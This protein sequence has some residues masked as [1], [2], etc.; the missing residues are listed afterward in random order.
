MDLSNEFI[1]KQDLLIILEHVNE[2]RDKALIQLIA[3]TGIYTDE[4]LN[5]NTTSLSFKNNTIQTN[6]KRNRILSI[7]TTTETLLKQWLSA[8]PKTSHNYIFFSLKA[9][10][11]PLTSRG[12]DNILRKWGTATG[13]RLNYRLLKNTFKRYKTH[14]EMPSKTQQQTIQI[15][16]KPLGKTLIIGCLFLKLCTSLF[17]LMDEQA[18]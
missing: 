9:P 4:L 3:Q 6:G 5:L 7:D 18:S 10:Y 16:T 11:D 12:I 14:P 8:K 1:P 13:K 17:K 2:S 15:P